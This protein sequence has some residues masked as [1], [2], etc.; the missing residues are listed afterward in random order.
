VTTEMQYLAVNTAVHA[1]TR[2]LLHAPNAIRWHGAPNPMNTTARDI[3][4]RAIVKDFIH[5]TFAI[6]ITMPIR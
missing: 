6:E 4:I 5:A 1:I 3:A 2:D